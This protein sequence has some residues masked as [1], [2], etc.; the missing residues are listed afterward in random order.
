M[1][2]NVRGG[3]VIGATAAALGAASA[4][5]GTV[6]YTQSQLD[7]T[8]GSAQFVTLVNPELHRPEPAWAMGDLPAGE[9]DQVLDVGLTS[10]ETSSYAAFGLSA[11]G[12]VFVTFGDPGVALGQTFESLFPGFSESELA[13]ALR[14]DDP[15]ISEFANLLGQTPGVETPYGEVSHA[16]EFSVGASYGTLLAS[17][18][19]IPSPGVL[20]PLLGAGGLM[21]GS[22]RRR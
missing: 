4:A 9:H 2:S 13:I 3:S 19:P 16:V 22:R 17:L 15:L 12:G 6:V 20:T 10:D 5:S 11:S 21:L 14:T 7:D 1:S 18:T 8:G